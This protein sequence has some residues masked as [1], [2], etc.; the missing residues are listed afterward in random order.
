MNYLANFINFLQATKNLSSKILA[1]YAGDLK[2]FFSFETDLLHP[3]ICT[4]ISHLSTDLKLK[5]TSIRKK[6]ITLKNFYDYLLTCEIITV[7]PFFV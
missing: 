7:S 4:Y 3:D 1:A 6:I 2:Q 5:D